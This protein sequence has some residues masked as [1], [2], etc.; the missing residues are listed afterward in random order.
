MRIKFAR[1]ILGVNIDHVATLRQARGTTFPEPAKAARMAQKA[2]AHGITIHLREDRRHIQD[3]D[4][5]A[6]RRA[7]HLPINLEM[8]LHPE[9]V[10]IALRFRPEKV[11][12]VPERRQEITTEGGLDLRPHAA[13]LRKVIPKLQK[14]KIEVS[15]FIDPDPE[16]IQLAAR[17]K[18][19]AIEIHTG[20]YA[21]ARG[22]AQKRELK[23]IKRAAALAHRLGLKVNAGHG[24][25]YENVQ[26]V[27][28]IP[29]IEELNIGFSIISEAVF[30]GLPEAVRKMKAAIQKP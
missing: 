16:Q 15:L 23:R 20:S 12:L 3:R 25:D 19:N 4:L 11:C 5:P 26:A 8:A 18:T 7:C 9:I 6:V 10:R 1:K 22:S 30:C 28:K 24:L 17:L 2:G 21:E 13:K 27:A 29:E 14:K